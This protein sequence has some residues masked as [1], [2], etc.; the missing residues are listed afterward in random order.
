MHIGHTYTH[1]IPVFLDPSARERHLYI[2]GA[3]GTGKTNLIENMLATD[4][5][6]GEGVAFFDP[7][8]DTA[9]RVI[10]HIPTQFRDKLAYFDFNSSRPIGLNFISDIPL[11]DRP[12]AA[13]N[14]VSSVVHI[15]GEE[16]VAFRSQQVLRNSVRS[17]M[18]TSG[19]TLLCIPRLLRDAEYRAGILRRGTDPVVLSYWRHTYDKYDDRRRAEVIDPILNKLDAFLSFPKI[20]GIVGQTTNTIDLRKIIDERRILIVNI[21]K[22]LIGEPALLLACLLMSSLSHAAF[23]RSNISE[24]DRVPFYLYG[25]EFQN[26]SIPSMSDDLSELRKYKLYFTLAHQFTAQIEDIVHKA[27]FANVASLICFR[28]GALDSPLLA[29]HYEDNPDRLQ[30][31]ANFTALLRPL[32]NGAPGDPRF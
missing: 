24:E 16:A 21:N 12:R 4:I 28:V 18:D 19:G 31:L 23:S 7:H 22:G 3:T 15:F 2:I 6:A 10:A 30:N 11:Q 14:I 27:I 20:R 5:Q 26:Y 13:A 25:D 29:R 17:L 9:Q 32:I 8:G 1:G